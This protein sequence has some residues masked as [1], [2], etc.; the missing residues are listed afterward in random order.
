MFGG[1]LSMAQHVVGFYLLGSSFSF[2]AVE[3]LVSEGF[4]NQR[5]ANRLFKD[6]KAL[7]M[8]S[9]RLRTHFSL[10]SHELANGLLIR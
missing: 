3:S 9:V 1:K 10:A 5:H 2:L 8:L 7:D 4:L 6:D